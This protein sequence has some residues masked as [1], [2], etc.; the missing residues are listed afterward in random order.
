MIEYR[1]G[2]LLKAKGL[3]A[4]ACN[5][6]GTWGAGIALQFQKRFPKAYKEYLEWCQKLKYELVGSYLKLKENEDIT[7]VC[8]FTSGTYGK[9]LPQPEIILANT[10]KAVD[11]L[12]ATIPYKGII[13]SNKFNSGLFNVHW[14]KTEDILKACLSK[15]PDV[16]W[17]VWEL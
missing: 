15:R 10:K 1:K 8:L 2:S 7:V 16:T 3:L 5:A 17:V 14:D 9:N 6:E 12:L 13:N 11:A 4:H